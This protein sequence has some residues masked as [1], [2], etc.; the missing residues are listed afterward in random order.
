VQAVA[1]VKQF[2][3]L[4]ASYTVTS[5]EIYRADFQ[6]PAQ[7][8]PRPELL[9]DVRFAGDLQASKDGSFTNAGKLTSSGGVVSNVDYS[10]LAASVRA[11]EG[12][13]AIESFSAKALDGTVSGNGVFRLDKDA[14]AF[15]LETRLDQIDLTKYFQYKFPS[16]TDVIEGRVDGTVAL[17]GAGSTWEQISKTL[18]GDGN[19][20]VVKGALLNVNLARELVAGVQKIPMV[21]ADFEQRMRAKNPKL[22]E[23]NETLFENLRGQVKIDNGRVQT[24]QVSLHNADFDVSGSGWFSFDKQ[25]NVGTKFLLSQ[26]LTK[27]IVAEVPAARYLADANG[28]IEIPVTISGNAMR[29]GVSLDTESVSKRLQESLVDEG[30]DKLK[31]KLRNLLGGD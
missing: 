9:R 18:S 11:D 16:L 17:D 20:L 14:P 31:D 7:K 10:N 25:M 4:V 28:R 2:D 27:D 12:N 13:V 5:P 3:P 1:S 21:P 29:P 22:F 26:R 24:E 23:G 30:K 15:E 19:A 8:M 6:V